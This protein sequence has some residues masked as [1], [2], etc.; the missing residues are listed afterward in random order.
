M[1]ITRNKFYEKNIFRLLSFSKFDKNKFHIEEMAYWKRKLFFENIDDIYAKRGRTSE[2][3][4]VALGNKRTDLEKFYMNQGYHCTMFRLLIA[5]VISNNL[6][7][8]DSLNLNLEF[9]ILYTVSTCVKK[10]YYHLLQFY[11]GKG[12]EK[13]FIVDSA[14]KLQKEKIKR[15]FTSF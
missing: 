3:I 15:Y 11:I 12:L 9:Y 14:N 2:G 10:D 1:I 7:Y 13:K 4:V 8:I 5:C 6:E